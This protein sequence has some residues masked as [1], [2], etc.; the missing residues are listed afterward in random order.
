MRRTLHDYSPTATW[1]VLQGT[2]SAIAGA[3]A[4]LASSIVTCPL[5]V[6]KTKL[7]AGTAH[8]VSSQYLTV[9]GT[10]RRI[11]QQEHIRGFYRGLGPTIFGY[12]PTWAIYFTVYDKVKAVISRRRN[13]HEE[14]LATHMTAALV[15]GMTSTCATNP[16]WVIRTRF[17]TQS[18]LDPSERYRHTWDALARIYRKEG[19]PGFYRGLLPSLFGISHVCIQFPL[20]EHLKRINKPTDGSDLSKTTILYCSSLSKMMAS[21]ITYPHEVI[22]TRLQ[23]ETA[24]PASTARS[25]SRLFDGI[26]DTCA[27]VYSESGVK[28]F[29]RGLSVNLARTVPASALTILTYEVLMRN[30]MKRTR[31]E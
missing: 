1:R 15:A 23:L 10:I 24:I 17:M 6:V 14:D 2:E 31:A 7:Q 26:R 9:G 25:G 18:A 12:L 3:A 30:L 20:Y 27:Q 11:W 13:A 28:G 5:D 19:I 16:F 8:G 22:R 21:V 29:Y 4:G